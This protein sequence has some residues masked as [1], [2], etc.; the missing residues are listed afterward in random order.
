MIIQNKQWNKKLE[1]PMTVQNPIFPLC[2]TICRL[3][4]LRSRLIDLAQDQDDPRRHVRL[5]VIPPPV[6][7][8]VGREV[9]G[10]HVHA[11]VPAEPLFVRVEDDL[12][13]ARHVD[14]DPVVDEGFLVMDWHKAGG[15]EEVRIP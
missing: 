6:P 9:L 10:L 12:V 2:L 14:P 1:T 3:T 4:T 5:Q 7:L 15:K 8:H 11:L 13:L